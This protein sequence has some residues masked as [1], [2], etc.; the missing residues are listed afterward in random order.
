M[1]VERKINP[2]THAVELWT[3]EWENQA[4][5]AARRVLLEKIADE[6]PLKPDPSRDMT[7]ASAICWATAVRS[8]TGRSRLL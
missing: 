4:G 1:F 7:Q 5:Q 2:T 8:A 6:Q 3:A